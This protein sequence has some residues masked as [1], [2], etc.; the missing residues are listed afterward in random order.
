MRPTI[1][2]LRADMSV[3]QMLRTTASQMQTRSSG[4]RSNSLR[5]LK[6]QNALRKLYESSWRDL[7]PS[8]IAL[9]ALFDAPLRNGVSYPSRDRG[10]G[11]AMVN[12]REIFAYDRISDQECELVPLTASE[13]QQYL[14]FR[15]S[16]ICQAIF[17]IRRCRQ[18]RPRAP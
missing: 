13:R 10:E 2:F 4:S 3:L 18:V 14:R 7:M 6:N 9:E 12:M 11:I 1:R 16:P 5:I 8:T 15:R 17:N